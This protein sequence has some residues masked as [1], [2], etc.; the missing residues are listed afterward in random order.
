MSRIWCATS[1]GQLFAVDGIPDSNILPKQKFRHMTGWWCDGDITHVLR[2]FAKQAD[3]ICNLRKVLTTTVRAALRNLLHE[4]QPIGDTS[5]VLDS[6]AS[7]HIMDFEARGYNIL[8]TIDWARMLPFGRVMK[9]VPR[10]AA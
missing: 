8:R 7:V 3:L 10:I 4:D 9:L 5:R 2:E 6:G 1:S